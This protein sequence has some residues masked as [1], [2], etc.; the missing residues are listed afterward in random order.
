IDAALPRH[1]RHRL[2]RPLHGVHDEEPVVDGRTRLRAEG[3]PRVTLARSLHQAAPQLRI[4]QT[5]L[6][7]VEGQGA[8]FL[9]HGKPVEGELR[10]EGE[11]GG[12]PAAMHLAEHAPACRRRLLEELQIAA[13]DVRRVLATEDAEGDG[14]PRLHGQL[15]EPAVI[16]LEPGIARVAIHTL[17]R[18][19]EDA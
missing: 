4:A 1:L 13:P 8:E 12:A 6:L 19:L 2:V 5:L 14:A 10:L 3:L 18:D 9:P 16:I 7:L 11:N 15:A 17:A